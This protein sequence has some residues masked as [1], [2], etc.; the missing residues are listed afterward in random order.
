M[1]VKYGIRILVEFECIMDVDFAIYTLIKYKY[2]KK[3]GVFYDYLM[4]S[5]DSKFI[6]TIMNIRH[7]INPLT[8]LLTE[9][10]LDEADN[11]YTQMVKTDYQTILN[12]C[13]ANDVFALME[14]YVKTDDIISVTVLCKDQSQVDIIEKLDSSKRF[15][16]IISERSKVNLSKFDTIWVGKFI[17][18][19]EFDGK[20]LSGKHIYTLRAKYNLEPNKV[21][22]IPKLDISIYVGKL[23]KI[24][25]VSPYKWFVMPADPLID[26]E[27]KEE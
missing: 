17:H 14:T 6:K 19:L 5:E 10:Y 11:L 16:T 8:T 2:N 15:K 20:Q 25:L 27:N 12:I 9:E 26:N 21:T 18:I 7:E 4:D 24:Y 22:E 1:S 3:P 23:N 13:E